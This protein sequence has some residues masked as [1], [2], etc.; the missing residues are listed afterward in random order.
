[1]SD[2]RRRFTVEEANELVPMLE[3]RWQEIMRL[4]ALVGDAHAQLTRLGEPP[5]ADTLERRGG[6]PEL[7]STRARFRA[8]LESMADAVGAIE[9]A[10]VA[11]KDLE[12]G[13]FDF[14]GEIDGRDVWLCWQFGEPRVEFWHELDSGFAS[15]RA[16]AA[17]EPSVPTRWVH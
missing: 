3:L 11:V 7:V 10:G 1:M 12:I 8:L 16:I 14:L 15:R 6:A 4:R 5:D 13:L 2:G 17:P 9:G